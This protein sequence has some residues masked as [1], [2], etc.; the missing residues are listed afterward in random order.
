MISSMMSSRVMIPIGRAAPSRRAPDFRDSRVTAGEWLHKE[1]CS[2]TREEGEAGM[3]TV[4]E[5]KEDADENHPNAHLTEN[6]RTGGE[7]DHRHLIWI[8]PRVLGSIDASRCHYPYPPRCGPASRICMTLFVPFENPLH[9][10]VYCPDVHTA[11]P[12]HRSLFIFT[13]P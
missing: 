7:K 11:T 1:A 6:R 4:S 10:T 5:G 2:R 13:T 9:P 12:S 3:G 8:H